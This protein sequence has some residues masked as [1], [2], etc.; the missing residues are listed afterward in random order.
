MTDLL[1]IDSLR[2]ERDDLWNER[3]RL[4]QWKDKHAK[5]VRRFHDTEGEAKQLR[6]TIKYIWRTYAWRY[7]KLAA[8]LR[9]RHARLCRT[10]RGMSG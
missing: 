1:T 10:E 2:R 3:N 5:A 8:D 9:D 6:D 7:P 4:L